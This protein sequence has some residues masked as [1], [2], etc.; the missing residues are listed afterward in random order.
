M[1][2]SAAAGT[3]T[4]MVVCYV[5]YDQYSMLIGASKMNS[6]AMASMLWQKTVDDMKA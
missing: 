5:E 1:A 4:E 3:L 2:D 6:I